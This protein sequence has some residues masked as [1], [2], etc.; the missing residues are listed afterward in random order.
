MEGGAPDQV[1][2]VG[3]GKPDAAGGFGDQRNRQT[4]I[5]QRRPQRRRPRAVIG[6]GKNFLVHMLLEKPV[7]LFEHDR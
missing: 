7:G 4:G 2:Y 5:L 6:S 3:C 1:G